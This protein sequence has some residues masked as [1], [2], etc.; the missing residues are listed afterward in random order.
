MPIK[1]PERSAVQKRLLQDFGAQVFR[2]R[3]ELGL[4]Q[5]ELSEKA[6]LHATYVGSV[7]NGE[8]N[9]ALVNVYAIA[10]ALGVGIDVLLPP[11]PRRR[12]V[13]TRE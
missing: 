1:P 4:T 5:M 7:E 11:V 10:Q 9:V 8:R 2:L 12:V 3:K 6:G 13:E